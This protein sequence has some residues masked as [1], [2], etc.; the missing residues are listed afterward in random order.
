M[1]FFKSYLILILSIPLEVYS[2]GPCLDSDPVSLLC[3]LCS[4]NYYLYPASPFS[5]PRSFS[6][7]L[8]LLK[9]T[10][11]L[12]NKIYVNSQRN[13]TLT[14]C[15]GSSNF[16]F[17][18][19]FMALKI[20]ENQTLQILISNIT[21]NLLGTTPILLF[22]DSNATQA[23]YIFR[24]KII[25]LTIQT[26]YCDE[27]NVAGCFG[28]RGQRAIVSLKQDNIY[29]FV[30]SIFYLK[31]MIIQANDVALYYSNSF[32][33]SALQCS[34]ND[35]MT[36]NTNSSLSNCY[37]YLKQATVD[38]TNPYGFL[39]MEFIFDCT[40]C[41]VPQ[42]KLENCN[43]QNFYSWSAQPRFFISLINILRPFVSIISINNVTFD[44]IFLF[45]GIISSNTNLD[46]FYVNIRDIDI[47]GF[48]K[49]D[50]N[51]TNAFVLQLNA[52]NFT[53]YNQFMIQPKQIDYLT[54]FNLDFLDLFMPL[55]NLTFSNSNI[56]NIDQSSY[57]TLFSMI[58][59]KKI[60][61]LSVISFNN[62]TFVQNF[63]YFLINMNSASIF[64]SIMI[65]N[66]CYFN[67]TNLA[68]NYNKINLT[69]QSTT[70]QNHLFQNPFIIMYTGILYITDCL[71]LN[72][73]IYPLNSSFIPFIK[74]TFSS[75]A[76]TVFY[77]NFTSNYTYEQVFI[78]NLSFI[79]SK[80]IT[81][82]SSKSTIRDFFVRDSVFDNIDIGTNP[83][84]YFNVE[85]TISF[86]NT[87]FNR[88]N[89][90]VVLS[91]DYC[92][93]RTYYRMNFTNSNSAFLK[94]LTISYTPVLHSIAVVFIE[95]LFENLTTVSVNL[96]VAEINYL[97]DLL[98]CVFVNSTL[99]NIQFIST[100]GNLMYFSHCE[101]AW[102]ANVNVTNIKGGSFLYLFNHN[103]VDSSGYSI[104]PSV[105]CTNLRVIN[106][107]G[108]VNIIR[109]DTM[110]HISISNSYFSSY[111]LFSSNWAFNL[112]CFPKCYLSIKNCIFE[113]LNSALFLTYQNIQSISIIN[114]TFHLNYGNKQGLTGGDLNLKF[115][116]SV[117]INDNPFQNFRSYL[118]NFNTMFIANFSF[119]YENYYNYF[120]FLSLWNNSNTTFG[121]KDCQI[122]NT[123][124][125]S[126]SIDV[127]N[128]LFLLNCLFSGISSNLGAIFVNNLVKLSIFNS[129]FINMTSIKTSGAISFAPFS[130]SFIINST[131]SI[132]NSLRGGVFYLESAYL[133]LKN[134]SFKLNMARDG[135]VLN[136]VKSTIILVDSYVES[137]Y[138][139]GRGS[140]LYSSN[141]KISITNCLFKNCSSNF[142]GG[143]LFFDY[144]ENITVTNTFFANNYAENGIIYVNGK[145][146]HYY[147]FQNLIFSNNSALTGAAFYIN[148]GIVVITLSLFQNN[149]AVNSLV[150]A[151]SSFSTVFI[152]LTTSLLLNNNLGTDPIKIQNADVLLDVLTIVDNYF[153]A[154]FM[155]LS[156]ANIKIFNSSM[157]YLVSGSMKLQNITI[158]NIPYFISIFQSDMLFLNN[159]V[160]MNRS[161]GGIYCKNCF[162]VCISDSIFSETI[163]SKGSSFYSD[164]SLFTNISSSIFC[165][166]RG[167]SLY[168]ENSIFYLWNSTFTNNNASSSDVYFSAKAIDSSQFITISSCYFTNNIGNMIYVELLFRLIMN[169]ISIISNSD[170]EYKSRAIFGKD[171][172]QFYI[173]NC[174][175]SNLFGMS[176]FYLVNTLTN[177]FTILNMA[178][179]FFSN[180]S[181]T[182]S[183]GALYIKGPHKVS[184]ISSVFR[185]NTAYS[186]GGAIF[187]DCTSSICSQIAI[188][189]S[190]FDS[191]RAE[192]SGGSIKSL[193]NIQKTVKSSNTFKHNVALVGNDISTSPNWFVVSQNKTFYYSLT[194]GKDLPFYTNVNTITIASGQGFD[195]YMILFDEFDNFLKDQSEGQFFLSFENQTI[196]ILNNMASINQGKAYF[197]NLI[198]IAPPN[199]ILQGNINY[200]DSI[201][202]L[203]YPIQITVR[204][205]IKGEIY[206][207]YQCI[208][209]SN[210]VYSLD[211]DPINSEKM[212]CDI[213]PENADCPGGCLI[214]PKPCY[215]RSS[216][217]SSSVIKCVYCDSCP[218]QNHYYQISDLNYPGQL[219]YNLTMEFEYI[220]PI[221]TYGNICYN[222]D[223]FF[224]KNSDGECV[225]CTNNVALYIRYFG[226]LALSL[227]FIAYQSHLALKF[228]ENSSQNRSLLKL[229]IN[230]S[231]YLSFMRNFPFPIAD[232]FNTV[233]DVNSKYVSV[234]PEEIANFDC[235]ISGYVDK[236]NIEAVKILLFSFLPIPVAIF[237]FSI[238]VI[239]NTVHKRLV[240]KKLNKKAENIQFI[241]LSSFI[242]TLY[243]FYSRLIL[244][245]FSL[246]RCIS[247]DDTKSAY[248]FADPNVECWTRESWHLTAIFFVFVPNLALWCIGWPLALYLILIIKRTTEIKKIQNSNSQRRRAT[249]FQTFDEKTKNNSTERVKN[250]SKKFIQLAT[251]SKRILSFRSSIKNSTQ[252]EILLSEKQ[253][254]EIFRKNAI[255][256][257]LTID[258]KHKYYYWEG[259]FYLTNILITTINIISDK[260]GMLPQISLLSFV[261][262]AMLGANEKLRPFRY[263]YLNSIAS[264]SYM[265]TIIT[266]VLMLMSIM[267]V[268]FE[269]QSVLYYCIMII[270]NVS[271]YGVW[272]VSFAR[273]FMKT[274][275]TD[276]WKKIIG[277]YSKVQTK[278]AKA[279]SRRKSKVIAWK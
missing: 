251:I 37:I 216:E 66:S 104:K 39:N 35:L 276:F 279:E 44:K 50:G 200:Q 271:F 41:N 111:L 268:N 277:V 254:D 70:I 120:D 45:R 74:M 142:L 91:H 28:D 27:E 274:S 20:T 6:N 86:R 159:I 116:E 67:N 232:K 81:F 249:N 246:L 76:N 103:K 15:D 221:G 8:C 196:K 207:D 144:M 259:F 84:C 22:G 179:T 17:D 109:M 1:N 61:V 243:A 173:D 245:A 89:S 201:T 118:T 263:D 95:V 267:G 183:G 101:Y 7:S 52:C 170:N 96:I 178:S 102:I 174:T 189:K 82:G 5:L 25:N 124:G 224:G 186:F 105:N 236:S 9:N 230:H 260:I 220:C 115:Q 60:N 208:L 129:Y 153:E 264:F 122:F 244:N 97:N 272:G 149:T 172:S 51:F 34:D 114:C 163:N 257:F 62:I 262:F 33:T 58:Y 209:C 127:G 133:I 214:I 239:F 256:H 187:I 151:Y 55:V 57:S 242:V 180:C 112:N 241:L 141:S 54:M 225:K 4:F 273:L 100:L 215:W 261:Y 90:G 240:L 130:S 42:L 247:I 56:S 24:R 219:K 147:Y 188:S 139:T 46:L 63:Y 48:L 93:N 121:L 137:C 143:V 99:N 83:F 73:A 71:I 140:F 78:K 154:E 40:F 75:S 59:I 49:S 160:S 68:I 197:Q 32:S 26:L 92:R 158:V 155:K 168:F 217:N 175:F 250:T 171:I 18:N 165:Q 203:V 10:T 123:V 198:V 177:N 13:C 218:S 190:L 156:Y 258:Y 16:P 182:L 166:S 248:L 211:E 72:V 181:T 270:L 131:F 38:A 128:D 212:T 169:S 148:G 64:N 278:I 132:G 252:A 88:F 47:S 36:I 231:Y 107:L 145:D 238:R 202:N 234:V 110:T 227:F 126:I 146:H 77:R 193:I 136:S 3:N 185:N 87:L 152:E 134:T 213:C 12:T 237:V 30:S 161:L 265:V 199:Q 253:S 164:T 229:L 157:I 21:I 23:Y 266:I 150:F 106:T 204:P 176:A 233:I 226:F 80:Y 192:K 113:K 275:L 167:G 205:C 53:R 162:N 206:L 138:S 222:C 117:L 184:I 125:Q 191:N 135:G 2:S 98:D 79:N 69:F 269:F 210:L 29:F 43:F 19:L 14:F 235:F 65:F 119:S 11:S 194:S 108:M 85:N 255:F 31:N 94:S 223:D 228:T 195:L